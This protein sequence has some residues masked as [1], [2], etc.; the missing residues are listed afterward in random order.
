M[1]WDLVTGRVLWAGAH[2]LWGTEGSISKDGSGAD[3]LLAAVHPDDCATVRS[4]RDQVV[5]GSD[6]GAYQC[7]HRV[8]GPDGRTRWLESRG[9]VERRSSGRAW[10]FV[11]ASLDITDRNRADEELRASEA[12]YRAAIDGQTQCILRLRP[13]RTELCQR[14]LLPLP[15]P[16]V[17][18]ASRSRRA[19]PEYPDL[20]ALPE[21][22]CPIAAVKHLAQLDA[23]VM[24]TQQGATQVV[25]RLDHGRPTLAFRCVSTCR[26]LRELD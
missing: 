1:E 3:D 20:S 5:A 6:A 25:I 17:L 16:A 11:G 23:G 14:C 4:A 9:R 13:N 10:C 18:C 2:A 26:Q 7:E 21:H 15:R 24:M 19:G 8:I 22:L 12:R